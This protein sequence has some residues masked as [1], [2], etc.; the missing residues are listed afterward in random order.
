MICERDLEF[1]FELVA[2]DATALFAGGPE[3]FRGQRKRS[4]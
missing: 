4:T 3:A 2:Q 1:E